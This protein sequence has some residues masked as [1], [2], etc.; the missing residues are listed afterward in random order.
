MFHL[1][2]IV[3]RKHVLLVYKI[4]NQLS[5]VITFTISVLLI[6]NL[7]YSTMRILDAVFC[8]RSSST[9]AETSLQLSVSISVIIFI[10]VTEAVIFKLVWKI[11]IYCKKKYDKEPRTETFRIPSAS[12]TKDNEDRLYGGSEVY[13]AQSMTLKI[14]SS[15]KLTGRTAVQLYSYSAK[16][17]TGIHHQYFLRLPRVMFRI[18]LVNFTLHPNAQRRQRLLQGQQRILLGS[19]S[20][21]AETFPEATKAARRTVDCRGTTKTSPET[22][23]T[24]PATRNASSS[25]AQCSRSTKTSP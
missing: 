9:S 6:K 2:S 13:P 5:M 14:R 20:R 11:A 16:K 24:P 22:T 15:V 12:A 4:P 21:R 7:L 19:N 23:N 3:V 18:H 25:A 8:I 1:L 10:S 17:S